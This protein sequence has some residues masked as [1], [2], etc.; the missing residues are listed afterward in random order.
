MLH[1]CVSEPQD[2]A[3][4]TD[5]GQ[6]DDILEPDSQGLSI[7]VPEAVVVDDH[8]NEND[9][10]INIDHD[11]PGSPPPHVEHP[12][13]VNDPD[14]VLQETQDALL[15]TRMGRVVRPPRRYPDVRF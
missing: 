6:E 11:E 2:D 14:N 10:V 1:E 12:E 9:N 7:I 13:T 15:T 5:C 3:A 4:L 8:V